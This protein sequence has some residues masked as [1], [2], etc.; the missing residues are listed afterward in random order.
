LALTAIFTLLLGIIAGLVA[1]INQDFLKEQYRWRVVMGA[2]VLTAAQEKEKTAKPGSDFKECA[3]GCPTVIVV[4][5]G[6]FIMGSPEEE[7]P[8]RDVTIARPFAVGRTTV[9]FAEWDICVAAGACPKVLD[10]GWGRGDRPVILVT[11]EEAKGY[12]TWLK[13]MTGKDY[14]LLTE[15]EF[16]YA[17]RAGSQTRYSFGDVETQLGDYAWYGDN[18]GNRTQ[19]VGTKKPNAFGLYDMHGNVEQWVEDCFTTYENKDAPSDGS[20]MLDQ[21]WVPNRGWERE[22]AYQRVTRGG[23]FFH[24]ANVLRSAHRS[25]EHQGEER[26]NRVSFRVARTLTP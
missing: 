25:G 8:Q 20:A 11:W 21:C 17:A 7:L 13:R 16:E 2:S 22:G 10:Y 23:S 24:A 3:N 5:A 18:S 26:S 14:R 12:V 9:T 4:P 15:S 19:P 6:K 1:F